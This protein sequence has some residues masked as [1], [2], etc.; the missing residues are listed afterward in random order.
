MIVP[1]IHPTCVVLGGGTAGWLTA[2]YVKVT[3]PFMDVTVVEDPEKP[4][5]IAGESGGRLLN[6][7]YEKLGIDI[8]DWADAVEATPKLGGKFYGWNGSNSHFNHAIIHDYKTEWSKKF[9][10]KE[11]GLLYLR[12]I[13][14]LRINLTDCFVSGK[15]LEDNK[16]LLNEDIF[17]SMWHFDSRANASYLKNIAQLRNINLIEG[18]YI[19]CNKKTDGCIESLRLEDGRVITGDWFFDCSG[20]ARLLLEKELNVE[21]VDYSQY[22]P[23][24]AVLPWWDNPCF[25]C[26]TVATTMDAGWTWKIGLKHRT[27]QG[28]LYNPDI[29][30]KDQAL[31]EIHQKFGSHIE[32]VASL[33]FTPSVLKQFW[34]KNVIGIGLSTGFM[35]PLEANGTGII[36]DAL[37]SLDRCWLPHGNEFNSDQF[38]AETWNSY[39]NIKDFLALHYRGK[40]RETEFWKSMNQ[41]TSSIPS[42]L[43]ERIENWKEFYQTGNMKNL[44]YYNSQYSLE[45][46]ATVI[47]GLD[48]IDPSLIQLGRISEYILEYYHK[49]KRLQ[50]LKY[51]DCIGI[52][53]WAIRK[54]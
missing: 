2:L 21:S 43:T 32:P 4:P 42:S 26:G 13:L 33:Q 51:N 3:Y 16:L 35:E 41:D 54:N 45:S 17:S 46:W 40:G 7:V 12:G 53:E 14:G 8:K 28:Y 47:Q 49:E 23:A 50:E 37:Y 24:R 36:I 11:E 38:N 10:T 44:H 18:R 25:D 39:D 15:L 52:K 30:S 31:D 27:G 1:D 34:K 29:L 19:G 6:F 48:L 9:P 20:F 5:I 22:F